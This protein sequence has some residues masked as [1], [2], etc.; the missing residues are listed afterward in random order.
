[1]KKEIRGLK[2]AG[3]ECRAA[4]RNVPLLQ[5]FSEND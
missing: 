4:R 3:T 1:M 5:E 2:I